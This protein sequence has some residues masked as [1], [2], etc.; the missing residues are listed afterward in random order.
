MAEA[1]RREPRLRGLVAGDGPE[2]A[3]VAARAAASGGAVRVLGHRSDVGDLI[4]AADAVCLSS[5][6]EAAPFSALEAMALGCPVVATAVGGID[7][8]VVS[9]VTGL[10]VPPDDPGALAAA[11][12]R[13]ASEDGLAAALGSAGQARQR[14]RFTAAAMCDSYAAILAEAAALG[15]AR[16]G[17]R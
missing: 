12:V 11:L 14:E 2:H 17:R 10:L 9:G 4:R 7:E 15:T 13:L 1:A 16:P 5:A 3:R 6:A 8:V